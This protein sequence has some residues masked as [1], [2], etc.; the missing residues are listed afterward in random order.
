VG[1]GGGGRGVGGGGG[2]VKVLTQG[3]WNP[4][5]KRK[6]LFTTPTTKGE[7]NWATDFQREYSAKHPMLESL[8]VQKKKGF[9]F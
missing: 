7:R 3:E 6:E 2:V 8:S 1:G 4:P 5:P 9:L